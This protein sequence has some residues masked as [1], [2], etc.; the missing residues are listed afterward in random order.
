[1]GD[2]KR[3][4]EILDEKGTNVRQLAFL[5]GIKATT[6]YSCIQKD[7][8]IRFDNALR[9]ANV[10]NIEPEEICS[11]S[12]F[13]GDLKEEEIY[14]TINDKLGILD[15]NRVKVYINNSLLPLMKLYGKN[16]L[17]EVDK[18]LTYF[19]ML[20]DDCRKEVVD[21][22]MFK[23]KSGKDPDRESQVKEIKTW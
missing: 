5:T 11:A 15:N 1:M 19:Y 6:L 22:L 12:P 14:P 7:S 4:K 10:L 17:P 18:L 23:L 20:N 9:I 21:F 2:G 16:D 13:S 3:L 8:N